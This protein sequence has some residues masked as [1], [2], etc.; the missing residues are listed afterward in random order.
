MTLAT[1][2]FDAAL[3][4]AIASCLTAGAVGLKRWAIDAWRNREPRQPDPMRWEE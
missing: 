4:G 1:V 2:V 3:W